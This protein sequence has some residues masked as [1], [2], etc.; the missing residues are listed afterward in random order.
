MV[1]IQYA[2][3]CALS[4]VFFAGILG[5][6]AW[7]DDIQDTILWSEGREAFALIEKYSL[8]LQ[9][10]DFKLTEEEVLKAHFQQGI[11][12]EISRAQYL[13]V[14]SDFL[15]RIDSKGKVI[16]LKNPDPADIKSKAEEEKQEISYFF[17]EESIL[18]IK[19][20]K[21]MKNN[22]MPDS[23][24]Q[25]VN[26]YCPEKLII[27]LRDNSGGYV[28]IT[29]QILSLFLHENKK[30]F[31]L[32]FNDEDKFYSSKTSSNQYWNLPCI[33]LINE[34]SKSCAEL[35][36]LVMKMNKRA[37]VIGQKSFG[38]AIGG[39][40]IIALR[41]RL[42]IKIKLFTLQVYIPKG[43][44]LD[45]LITYQDEGIEPDIEVINDTGL[46]K[47]LVAAIEYLQSSQS[48]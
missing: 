42:Q 33:I 19:F 32:K 44:S 25:M 35:F 46:D 9:K 20:P 16:D 12:S 28:D 14:L 43:N 34:N 29:H 40:P 41:D 3:R 21:K 45:E 1:I 5:S 8:N 36:A 2:K 10:I 17:Y 22:H 31:I 37:I 15:I 6:H 7:A 24:I 30:L 11:P 13:E 39:S 23:I 27:D 26:A 47:Q 4:L 48:K 18:H 38:K